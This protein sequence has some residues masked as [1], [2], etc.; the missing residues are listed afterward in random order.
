MRKFDYS[1]LE[2]DSLPSNIVSYLFSIE[3]NQTITE[4]FKFAYPSVF[5]NLIKIAK[6][7]SIKSSNE[8]EGIVTTDKR[9][10]SIVNEKTEPLNHNEKEIAGYR[11]ALEMIHAQYDSID[12]SD[13]DLLLLHK[14]LLGHTDSKTAGS[15]KK[16]NNVIAEV[17]SD[18]TRL[19]RYA[20]PSALDTP[21]YMEQMELAFYD[22]RQN[23]NINQLLL[24][25]CFVLDFLCIHPFEDGNGR[26][27]RLISLLLLYKD[28]Y[29]VGKYISLEYM[30][31]KNK[32]AYYQKLYES[33]SG[34][35]E[36]KN[37]Y[38]PFVEYFLLM[39]QSTYNELSSR[40]EIIKGK[41]LNK[42]ERIEETLKKTL[43]K[44]TKQ[45][46]HNLWPDISITTIELELSKLL[47][48]G[49]IKKIGTTSDSSYVWINSI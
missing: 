44:I 17:R 41:K 21:T 13:K 9:I 12:V 34:W 1:F 6:V 7:Q 30:I 10:E 2:K 24:I 26:M 19:V 42:A 31:N 11:D 4:G 5:S 48:K 33:S 22:A 27:S 16:V 40:Y 46:L 23:S 25:P 37:T 18:G 47:K 35:S 38:W 28:G 29:D 14:T 49:L 20:P 3:R 39:L 36:N 45:E 43:G 8:I 32:A 15:F